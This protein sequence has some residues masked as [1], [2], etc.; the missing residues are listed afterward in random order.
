MV[1]LV[2]FSL[3]AV[4]S[5]NTTTRS[6]STCCLTFCS[7]C[8]WAAQLR[9]SRRSGCVCS[10]TP[11]QHLQV[12]EKEKVC[13][14]TVNIPQV[15]EEMLTVLTEGDGRGGARVQETASTLSQLS[16]QTVFSMLSHLKQ[17]SR[18]ILC[19]KSKQNGRR[20]VPVNRHRVRFKVV[21]SIC[22]V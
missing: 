6:P 16:I 15:T 14:N 5:S 20:L 17:W 4:S 22:F 21:C 10:L 19:S 9:S 2:R 11:G 8:C 1:S 13:Y 3:A 18:H 12:K 7:T